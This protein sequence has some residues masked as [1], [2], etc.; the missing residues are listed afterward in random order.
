M[1]LG[2]DIVVCDEGHVLRNSKSAIS[3]AMNKVKTRRRII[4]TGTPLQ[5]NLCECKLS[6]VR[7][8][9]IARSLFLSWYYK[10]LLNFRIT[11]IDCI[12][13]FHSLSPV[14][15][16][17]FHMME[18]SSIY[19][20]IGNYSLNIKCHFLIFYP[21]DHCMVSFVKPNL[22]GTLKEF[23]NSFI[24]P[25]ENGQ[26]ADSTDFDVKL[27]KRRCHVLHKMLEGCVQVS[28]L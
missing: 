26:C 13:Y 20:D 9:V 22:L 12:L 19:I 6:S 25:I 16:L 23:S 14:E 11:Y 10:Y 17:V 8:A 4:L 15:M 3:I 21:T 1:F 24:R 5:N 28:I 2:P 27:M 18:S 7:H